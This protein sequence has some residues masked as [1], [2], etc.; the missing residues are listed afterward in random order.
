[1]S[2]SRSSTL[3]LALGAAARPGRPCGAIR[4]PQ[5]PGAARPASLRR[6]KTEPRK[7]AGMTTRRGFMSAALGRACGRKGGMDRVATVINAIRAARPGALVLDDGN[8]RHGSM[9]ALRTDGQDMVNVMHA[10]GVNAMTSHWE[11][12]LGSAR[13]HASVEALPFPF[14]GQNIFAAEWNEPAFDPPAFAPPAF[15]PPAFDHPAFA[16]CA[17]FERGGARIAV[18]GQAFP[19]TPIANPGWMFPEYAF[20][21]REERMQAIVDEVRAGGADPVVV[22][23]HN[24]FDVDR[25]MAGRVKGIDVIRTGHPQD[26]LPQPAPFGQTLRIARG[27]HGKVVSRLGLEVEGGR[28][29]GFRHRLIPVFADVI[30]PDP[31]MAARSAAA[32]PS[33]STPIRRSL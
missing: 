5:E 12:T 28:M 22:L 1:M 33:V 17:V 23:S 26:A 24:G 14:L 30:A 16:P 20:G 8:T 2:L 32:A 11:W 25:K 21:L 4:R 18:I 6:R 19:Y 7:Y 31:A 13:V 27:S 9:P 3:A 15:D 10:L 29:A